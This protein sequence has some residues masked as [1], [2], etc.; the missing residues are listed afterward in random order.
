MKKVFQNR[1]VIDQSKTGEKLL[2]SSIR[3]ALLSTMLLTPVLAQALGLGTLTTNSSLNEPFDAKIELLNSSSDELQ[4]LTVE[5]GGVDQFKSAGIERPFLLS[6]LKFAI[7][8]DPAGNYLHITSQESIK[9]PFLNFLLEI[10]WAKGRLIR[11]YTALLDPPVFDT[12]TRIADTTETAVPEPVAEVPV[13]TPENIK[14]EQLPDAT[15]VSDMEVQAGTVVESGSVPSTTETAPAAKPTIAHEEPV[16]Y[17]ESFQQHS[18]SF[19]SGDSNYTTSRGDTLWAIARQSR[20]D[21]SVSVQQMMLSLLNTNPSAFINSNINALKTGQ[22][23]RIP[24]NSEINQLSK[25]E[26]IALVKEHNTLWDDY[27]QGLASKVALRPAG[28]VTSMGTAVDKVVEEE[29]IEEPEVRLVSATDDTTVSED[30]A[31]GAGNEADTKSLEDELALANEQRV[32]SESEN[33]ELKAKLKESEE[34]AELLKQQVELKNQE[35]AA[36][37]QKL[38]E[39]D[40]AEEEANAKAAEEEANARAA[41]E[42]ANAKVAEE[43]ANAKAA[44]EEANAKAAEEEANAKAAEEEANAKAAEEE[45]NAKAAEEEANAKAA[46]EEANAKAA[47]EEANAKAA[48]EEAN[49]EESIDDILAQLEDEKAVESSY[50]EYDPGLASPDVTYSEYNAPAE[51]LAGKETAAQ[52]YSS[53]DADTVVSGNEMQETP[54]AQSGSESEQLAEETVEVDERQVGAGLLDKIKGMLPAG[55]TDSIPG[56]IKTVIAIALG[57]LGLFLLSIFKLFGRGRKDDAEVLDLLDPEELDD[58]DGV[59]DTALEEVTEATIP[60][61]KLDQETLENID[62]ESQ[63]AAAEFD[64]DFEE[65]TFDEETADEISELAEDIEPDEDGLTTEGLVNLENTLDQI[66]PLLEQTDESG[67]DED[68]LEEVNLSLAYEQFDKAEALVNKAIEDNPDEDGYKLRLLEVH[69]AANN[70]EAYENAAQSLHEK[71]DG[72]GHLWESA[73]AMWAEMSPERDLFEVTGDDDTESLETSTD[74]KNSEVFDISSASTGV[75][76]GMSAVG[77]GAALLA[78]EADDESE[79]INV[80]DEEATSFEATEMVDI[81]AGETETPEAADDFLNI[82]E[83]SGAG[84]DLSLTKE[85]DSAVNLDDGLDFEID[86]QASTA[87]GE[88]D[89]LSI[90]MLDITSAGSVDDVTGE[91]SDADAEELFEL[92]S[93]FK[94]VDENVL[95]ATSIEPEE[96]AEILEFSSDDVVETSEESLDPELTMGSDSDDKSSAGD[97]ELESLAK[98]LEDTISG[99]DAGGLDDLSFEFDPD[100]TLESTLTS[101]LGVTTDID[102][103]NEGDEIDTKLNL[104]KAYIELG[105]LMALKIFFMKSVLMEMKN[106][107]KTQRISFNKLIN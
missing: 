60:D 17:H 96:S 91:T 64:L 41:E 75:L 106:K 78:S 57:L 103:E 33:T 84:D 22:V 26:A 63:N 62:V 98:S 42:E 30:A 83:Q 47:E 43:E 53:E 23:L 38:R 101:T 68:P 52:Y 32:S 89:P 28:A 5:L 49:A 34:I 7:V 11:E 16:V 73:V 80:A 77:T 2:R 99:L 48:E 14:I 18:Q 51:S 74:S 61:E 87:D 27:R 25:R 35:L 82:A 15:L 105:I 55:L 3:K 37:Q 58:T 8:E 19:S 50:L 95:S 46:E 9:E 88:E 10:N 93:E 104:A 31:T 76:A 72:E 94:A 29:V 21:S 45:A 69:Y 44:E 67:L 4:T 65:D 85:N 59:F 6:S 79:F 92:T 24:D 81:S 71:T 40:L 100:G 70:K 86:D 54:A 66:K 97:D 1:S 13:Q 12:N 102:L 56:G 39:T 20:P 107:R 36:L 90:D